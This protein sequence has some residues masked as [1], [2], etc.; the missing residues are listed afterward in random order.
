M[1]LRMTSRFRLFGCTAFLVAA[2]A[3][4]QTTEVTGGPT[5]SKHHPGPAGLEAWTLDYEVPLHTESYPEVLVIARKGQI[6]RKIDG[7]PFV[8]NWIF[9]KNGRQIAYEA[10]PLHFG[11]NCILTDVTTGKQ[12][13]TYD[14][15]FKLPP[16]APAW[17]EELETVH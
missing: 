2:L 15:F 3:Q 5:E 13:A 9:L 8:W 14:C 10:G 17:V 11:M 6:I 16:D 4:S 12:L 7:E 1:E